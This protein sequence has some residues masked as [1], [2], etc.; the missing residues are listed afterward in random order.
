MDNKTWKERNVDLDTGST[1]ESPSSDKMIDNTT[2][3]DLE[4]TDTYYS[5]LTPDVLC[6]HA[7]QQ[8]GNRLLNNS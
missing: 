2:V 8:R 3:E 6:R 1:A 5:K 7:S 4:K